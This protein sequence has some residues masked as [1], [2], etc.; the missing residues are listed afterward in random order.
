MDTAWQDEDDC[1][2]QEQGQDTPQEAV[3]PG[4]VTPFLQLY[5]C[6]WKEVAVA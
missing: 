3:E 2:P 6:V 1:T 4:K 5:V